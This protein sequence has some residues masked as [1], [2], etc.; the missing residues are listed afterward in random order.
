MHV[1]HFIDKSWIVQK[2]FQ[3]KD[4]PVKVFY[5]LIAWAIGEES[6]IDHDLAGA[7][8]VL[9]RLGTYATHPEAWELNNLAKEALKPWV[10]LVHKL[11]QIEQL[12]QTSDQGEGQNQG[13]RRDRDG[14]VSSLQAEL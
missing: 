6:E 8:V 10:L 2:A 3:P 4:L 9:D 11:E 14:E 13:K 1:H 5:S 7:K 12:E